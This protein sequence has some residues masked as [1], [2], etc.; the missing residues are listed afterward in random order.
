MAAIIMNNVKKMHAS[1]N[2][3]Y[4]CLYDYY[5]LG[6]KKYRLAKLYSKSPVTIS[7]WIQQFE[8][9]G[10]LQK[11]TARKIV[12]KKFSTEKREWLVNQY[13]ANPVMFH[14]E[15]A[16]LFHRKFLVK[17]SSSSIS[18]ILL[19]ASLTYKVIERRAIQ[20]QLAQIHRFCTELRSFPWLLENLV[21][22][23]EV[24]FDNK[25]MLRKRGYAIKG[26]RLIYRGEYVRRPRVSLLCFLGTTGI[27]NTYKTDGTFN[28]LKF[29]QSCKKFAL[30]YDSCVQRYPGVNSVWIMDQARI[31]RDKNL[32][33]YLRSLGI[34]VVFLPSYSPFYNPIEF[35]FGYI[36]RELKRIYQE[37]SR[38]KI[39][40]VISEAVEKFSNKNM[41]R[42]Y[43]KCGYL[44]NGLFDPTI[45]F[46]QKLT[47]FG[48]N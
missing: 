33:E 5:F 34:V 48:Y 42:I 8:K 16:E 19:E 6:M 22:L 41:K 12:Y 3:K 13:K 23:D 21:F 44:S 24:S 46:A 10:T 36:K 38:K 29:L 30:S 18:T 14:D 17:I 26:E 7:Q 11:E 28:R 15:A 4:H 9:N 47:K 40:L 1:E 43:K 27:L 35:V 31:H 2:T 37:N 32:V 45:G 20:I 25:D 39:D